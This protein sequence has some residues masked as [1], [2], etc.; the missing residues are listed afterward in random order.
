M[1]KAVFRKLNDGWNAEPNDPAEAIIVHGNAVEL[2][3]ALN[4]WAF[5]ATVGD[6]ATLR[7]SRCV[8]WRLGAP[9]DEGW[10]RGQGRYDTATH[11]WGEFYEIVD[12]APP[13]GEPSDW[14]IL[15]GE[16]EHPRHF[17]FYLR[18]NTFECYASEWTLSR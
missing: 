5:H 3:F 18:D 11:S 15:D 1:T 6:R 4:P 16:C 8:R 10:Y 14:H 13:V 7:F 12:P 9:N 2:S 17:L